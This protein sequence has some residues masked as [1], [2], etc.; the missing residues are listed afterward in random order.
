MLG[1]SRTYV[2]LLC[3]DKR[4]PSKKIANMLAKLMLTYDL[5]VDLQAHEHLTCPPQISFPNINLSISIM[6]YLVKMLY[7]TVSLGSCNPK[8][9]ALVPK[10]N[11]G[12]INIYYEVHGDGETVALVMGLGGGLPWLF[13]QVTAL[14]KQ[15]QV[16]AF[17][18]RGTGGSDAPDIPYTMEMMAGDLYLLL[19]AIGVKTAHVFGISMGGMIA[20]HF[21]LLYPEK[22]KSLILGATTCG[23]THRIIP[24]MEAIRVLFDMDRMQTLTPEERAME[25]LPFVFSQEFI[26]NNQALIQQLLAKMVGHVTPLHGYMRQ[27]AAIMGH[28]TYERL[29]EIKVPTMVIAGDAD[30]LVPVENSRLIASRI[31]NAE[32]VILEKMGHGFNIEASDVVND[33]VLRFLRQHSHSR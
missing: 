18:N 24:D 5:D 22:V 16:V 29:P 2:T 12:D 4:K 15:Y 26:N 21:A 6:K 9:E 10:S 30:K 31:P 11:V 13:Q 1:V 23:G 27:A 33:T 8:R 17:D 20:Q 7:N 19:G 3:Q 32:L 25:T 28:D 14:S